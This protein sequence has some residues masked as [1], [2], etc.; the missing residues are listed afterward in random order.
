MSLTFQCGD[1]KKPLASVGV[2]GKSGNKVVLDGD[3]SFIFNRKSGTHT[4]IEYKNGM[5][6]VSLY[7]KK[8]SVF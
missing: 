4:P 5:Y 8:A 1:V 3:R 2:L 6:S 7:V